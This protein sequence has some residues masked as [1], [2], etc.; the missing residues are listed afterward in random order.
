MEVIGYKCF[1]EDM[2]NRYG[3]QLEV[4][5]VYTALGDVEF[6]NDALH[7][8]HMCKNMED[9]FIYFKS[10]EEDVSICLVKGTGKI[11]TAEDDYK[12]SYDMYSVENLEILKKLSREEIIDYG[13]NLHSFRAEKFV[14]DFKL[15]DDEIEMFKEKYKN[16]YGVLQYIDYYQLNNKEAFNRK[17]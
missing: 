14:R 4:G 9:T 15:N 6:G 12:G 8:F 2:T 5:K 13:L 11:V 3:K 1:N 17:L 7:G 10:K 16:D